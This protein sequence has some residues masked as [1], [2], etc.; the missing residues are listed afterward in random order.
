MH[1]FINYIINYPIVK[2]ILC[3][4]RD[5][6]KRYFEYFVIKA[7]TK[8]FE[9]KKINILVNFRIQIKPLDSIFSIKLCLLFEPFI[10]IIVVMNQ[11]LLSHDIKTSLMI[12][13][14]PI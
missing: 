7:I 3:R 6:N 10:G 2:K 11:E 12:T 5:Q 8:N 4:L 13:I 14:Q 1:N 9:N